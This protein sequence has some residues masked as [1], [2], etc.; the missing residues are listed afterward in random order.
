MKNILKIILTIAITIATISFTIVIFTDVNFSIYRKLI[1]IVSLV[2]VYYLANKHNFK[3]V[4]I[5]SIISFV[6]GLISL[7]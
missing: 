5:F 1:L 4:K 7:M 2:V 3:Y 6:L